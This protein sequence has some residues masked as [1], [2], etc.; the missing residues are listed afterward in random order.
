M[1]NFE[2]KLLPPEL[3]AAYRWG[4]IVAAIGGVVL[5]LPG[6]ELWHAAGPF[7]T[8]H[9]KLEC[10]ECHSP[11]PGNFVGQAFNNLTHAV[12]LADSAPHFIYAPAGNEECLECHERP[13]DHHPLTEFMEPEFAEARQAMGVQFCVSCHQQH[14]GIRVSVA[15]RAVCQYC[16]DD[17]ALRDDP[18]DTPHTTL[19]SEQRWE[20]CMGCHDFHGNHEGEVPTMMSE[21][22]P[23]EQIQQYFDGGE[24]PYGHRRLTVIQTMRSRQGDL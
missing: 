24:S 5:L 9:T 21:V 6:R 8:G 16:H 22:L 7:N 15:P 20:T 11:A 18:I 19:I 2:W 17:M 13:D 14:L 1:T 10:N 12:G 4:L 23:E 3:Q